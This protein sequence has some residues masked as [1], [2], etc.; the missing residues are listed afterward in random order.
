[1]TAGV[2]SVCI[3]VACTDICILKSTQTTSMPLE[4]S[5]T[6]KGTL[7]GIK[8]TLQEYTKPPIV[9]EPD[10][11][12]SKYQT[13]ELQGGQNYELG[14]KLHVQFWKGGLPGVLRHSTNQNSL[15]PD[16]TPSSGPVWPGHGE[17]TQNIMAD[18]I[19]KC[20]HMRI[21]PETECL[22]ISLETQNGMGICS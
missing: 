5:K 14:V 7:H 10:L 6:L 3:G 9:W 19:V 1:M 2:D 4:P 16:H 11:H 17:Y 8:C 21:L 13:M 22:S 18:Y 15:M 20:A 12:R